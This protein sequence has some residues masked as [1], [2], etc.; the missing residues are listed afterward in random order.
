MRRI[1]RL[2]PLMVLVFGLCSC[3]TAVDLSYVMA[4]IEAAQP[5]VED[6]AAKGCKQITVAPAL[7]V[8]WNEEGHTTFGGGVFVGCTAE[9][10]IVEFQCHQ[11]ATPESKAWCQ[12]LRLWVLK[13]QEDAP[14]TE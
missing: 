2:F 4:S 9:H 8:D 6:Y 14:P 12:K 5:I 3:A 13:M 11:A 1:T 7:T 10:Q